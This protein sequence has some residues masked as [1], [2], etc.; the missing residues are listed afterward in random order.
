MKYSRSNYLL[1]NTLIFTLGNIGSKVISF[2]LIPLYTNILTTAQYGV[3]DLI[4]TIVTVA[5][6]IL[7]LNICESVM[8]FGLDKDVTKTKIYK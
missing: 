8:R 3:T 7:T 2:F 6:P 5:V 4:T 1:K